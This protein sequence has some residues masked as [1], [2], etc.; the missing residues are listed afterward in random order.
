MGR[1]ITFADARKKGEEVLI[2][3]NY[4][5]D[6]FWNYAIRLDE[7][8]KRYINTIQIIE[9]GIAVG[10]LSEQSEGYP[11]PGK[12]VVDYEKGI[13][14]TNPVNVISTVRVS[15]YGT[16]SVWLAE[17]AQTALNSA[18]TTFLTVAEMKDAIGT[19]GAEA[20]CLDMPRQVW[21]W[22]IILKEWIPIS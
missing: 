13:I 2:E 9:N 22:D 21:R 3:K 20:I 10:T 17:D 8:P 15:Y 6:E 16:G 18:R 1:N 14:Q 11:N 5:V 7:I 12:F 4:A 19:L